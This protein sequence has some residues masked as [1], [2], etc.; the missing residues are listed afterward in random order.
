MLYARQASEKEANSNRSRPLAWDEI[1]RAKLRKEA[2]AMKVEI[3]L[4]SCQRV[5]DQVVKYVRRP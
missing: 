1:E 3:E 4:K 2:E 5:T